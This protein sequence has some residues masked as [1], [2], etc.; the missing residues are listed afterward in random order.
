MALGARC[1]V[2]SETRW[3][4]IYVLIVFLAKHYQDIVNLDFHLPMEVF[5]FGALIEPLFK[6]LERFEKRS[7]LF[8]M[9][10]QLLGWFFARLEELQKRFNDNPCIVEVVNLISAAVRARFTAQNNSLAQIADYIAT[11]GDHTEALAPDLGKRYPVEKFYEDLLSDIA[12]AHLFEEADA[13]RTEEQPEE[14]ED[15]D[16]EEGDGRPP[17]CPALPYRHGESATSINTWTATAEAAT[18]QQADG[19]GAMGRKLIR[20]YGDRSGWDPDKTKTCQQQFVGWIRE[21][22]R[23]IEEWRAEGLGD[24]VLLWS[25]L[26]TSSKWDVLAEYA[27]VLLS[28]PIAE[29][30]NER[31][32]STRRYVVG[33]RGGR[34]KNPLVTARVRIHGAP[35]KAPGKG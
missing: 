4:H 5:A 29:A 18:A 26:G 21:H 35:E 33:E 28:M 10:E 2:F 1:P 17:P 34:T 31:F 14:G 19:I 23:I 25:T 16:E 15:A 27:D 20:D 24:P 9:R 3:C 32:F 22:A 7:T 12:V 11:G 30:E 6:W 13:E 8:Y